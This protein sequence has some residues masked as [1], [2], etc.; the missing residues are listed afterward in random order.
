LTPPSNRITPCP[1][2]ASERNFRKRRLARGLTLD[3]AGVHDQDFGRRAWPKSS[4][5]IFRIFR[6]WL[7][8]KAFCSST[9]NFSM[10]MSPEFM[11]AFENSAHMTV[12]GYSYLQDNR[13]PSRFGTG[14]AKIGK[15]IGTSLMPF[16]IGVVISSSGF[17]S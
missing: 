16:V 17:L 2:K 11:E 14:R 8:Q 9:E 6:A 15:A 13:S 4:G 7:T 3:E 12:D 5:T 10:S 1:S